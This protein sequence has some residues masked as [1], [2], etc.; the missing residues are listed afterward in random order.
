[1]QLRVENQVASDKQKGDL[2][3]TASTESLEPTVPPETNGPSTDPTD[4]VGTHPDSKGGIPL[5]YSKNHTT[6][7]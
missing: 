7:D 2:R 6:K 1:M 3:V 4:R 5:L